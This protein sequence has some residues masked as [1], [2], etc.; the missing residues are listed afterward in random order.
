MKMGIKPLNVVE[1]LSMSSESLA[2]F[3]EQIITAENVRS[4]STTSLQQ[5]VV[6]MSEKII[7][8]F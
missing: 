3:A 4:T 6:R 2:K 1:V 8:N 5:L 7:K